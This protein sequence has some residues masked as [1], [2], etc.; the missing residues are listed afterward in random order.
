MSVIAASARGASY[1]AG[2][3]ILLAAGLVLSSG[4]LIL[5]Q[6]DV[7]TGWQIQLYRSIGMVTALLGVIAWQ[8]RGRVDAPFRAMG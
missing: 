6:I 7:A 2:L 8:Y 1:A 3:V 5:R 4:G